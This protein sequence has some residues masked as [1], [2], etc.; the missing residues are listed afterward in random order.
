MVEDGAEVDLAEVQEVDSAVLEAEALVGV[1]QVESGDYFNY[2]CCI[3]LQ[4][5]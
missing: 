4:F 1:V 2:F 3:H 5:S